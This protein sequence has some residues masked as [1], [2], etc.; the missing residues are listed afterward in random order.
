M[1]SQNFNF[2]KSIEQLQQIADS[3]ESA[4]TSL[5]DAIGLFEKGIKLSKECS[6]YLENAK[7]KIISLT[8]AESE[9]TDNG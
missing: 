5:D 9:E 4:D 3:L 8:D 6:S 7:Q 2:E 1:A